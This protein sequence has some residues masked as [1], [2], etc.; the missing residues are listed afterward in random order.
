[1]G[2]TVISPAFSVNGPGSVLACRFARDGSGLAAGAE[3]DGDSIAGLSFRKVQ[4]D[5]QHGDIDAVQA[6][7]EKDGIFSL[8][9]WA[10][11]QGDKAATRLRPPYICPLCGRGLGQ[12]E[13]STKKKNEQPE[14]GHE[15]RWISKRSGLY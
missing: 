12:Q 8:I 3:F 1:M 11:A 9:E 15:A 14:H 6:G 7:Q 10:V 4:V 2:F 13:N 5:G